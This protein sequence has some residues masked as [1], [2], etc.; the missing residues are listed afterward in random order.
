[1]FT[2]AR[3]AYKLVAV[4]CATLRYT[5]CKHVHLVCMHCSQSSDELD[6]QVLQLHTD[7]IEQGDQMLQQHSQSSDE[8]VVLP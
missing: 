5:V 6:D 7:S 8:Q 3:T 2:V 4:H 1:M